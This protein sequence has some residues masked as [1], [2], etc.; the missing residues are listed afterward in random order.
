MTLEEALQNFLSA[1]AAKKAAVSTNAAAT[2]A[3]L[4][5]EKDYTIETPKKCAALM[6]SSLTRLVESKNLEQEAFQAAIEANLA[7]AKATADLN[8]ARDE[9]LTGPPVVENVTGQAQA[10]A[11]GV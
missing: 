10:Q 2:Q 7:L 9:E 4:A 5:A 1:S 11:A 8:A 6:A 3:T